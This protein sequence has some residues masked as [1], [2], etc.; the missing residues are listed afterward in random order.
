MH[1]L[2]R[3]LSDRFWLDFAMFTMYARLLFCYIWLN[4]L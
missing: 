3:V 4:N 1:L 2:S